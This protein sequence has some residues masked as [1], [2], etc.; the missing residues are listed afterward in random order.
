MTNLILPQKVAIQLTD[1]TGKPL[2]IPDVLFEV[3]LFAQHKNDFDLGPYVSDSFGVVLITHD[4]LKH[5]IQATY[6]SGLMDY[7]IGTCFSVVEITLLTPDDIQKRLKVRQTVWNLLLDGEEAR[8]GSLNSLIDAYK[9]ARNN[10][11]QSWSVF[12]RIRDEWDGAKQEYLY[13][14]PVK[15]LSS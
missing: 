11:F 2:A 7:A 6:S 13:F 9:R 4:D 5:D 1:P 14:F 8:W 10:Q 12:P 3:H 15:H